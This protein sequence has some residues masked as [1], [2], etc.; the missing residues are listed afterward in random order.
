MELMHCNDAALPNINDLMDEV[1]EE[2]WVA[3]EDAREIDLSL[4]FIKNL[5]LEMAPRIL[6]SMVEQG[7][8]QKKGDSP[9]PLGRKIAS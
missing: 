6:E 5:P 4:P 9:A 7:L 1:M 2:F 3:K 8:A